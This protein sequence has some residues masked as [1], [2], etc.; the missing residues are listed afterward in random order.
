MFDPIPPDQPFVFSCSGSAD[1]GGI[2][3]GASRKLSSEGVARM[4]C[5]A[6]IGARVEHIVANTEMAE[7]LIAIDGCENDCGRKM[8]EAAGFRPALHIRI[9]DLGMEKGNTPVTPERV[10]DV[11]DE[12]LRRLRELS[13]TGDEPAP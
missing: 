12:V 11:V 5:L 7:S 2:S 10:Q 6:G 1:V 3:D 8:L 13:D 9:T 4:Y